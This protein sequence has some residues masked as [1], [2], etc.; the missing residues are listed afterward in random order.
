M[1]DATLDSRF[2]SVLKDYPAHQHER[3]E[4]EVW[5][6]QNLSFA[7]PEL[8]W[9]NERWLEMERLTPI[10]ELGPE[11]S[12]KYAGPLREL[13]QRLHNEGWWHCD[14][15]LVNV[16][17]HPARGP[18]LIDWENLRPAEGNVS[19]D[20]YGARSAGVPQRWKVPGDNG[21]FW[22]GPWRNCPANYWGE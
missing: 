7:T 6:Y 22:G 14:V 10:L 2:T 11:R 9:H 18:L 16:V 3:W 15:S 4:R 19:Y 1:S 5:A 21:V 20:L 12:R 8:W 13:L 17:V